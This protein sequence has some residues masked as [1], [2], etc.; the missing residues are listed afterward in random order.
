MVEVFQAA[1]VKIYVFIVFKFIFIMRTT[2]SYQYFSINH[3]FINNET[4]VDLRGWNIRFINHVFSGMF[5]IVF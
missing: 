5:R 4:V 3:I 1:V 2:K